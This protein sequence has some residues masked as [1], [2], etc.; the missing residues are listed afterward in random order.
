MIGEL[1]D[2]DARTRHDS[3]GID[4]AATERQ[5]KRLIEMEGRWRASWADATIVERSEF[6]WLRPACG[7]GWWGRTAAGKRRCCG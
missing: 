3:A 2:V 1:A 5:T 7:L 6:C 4:F